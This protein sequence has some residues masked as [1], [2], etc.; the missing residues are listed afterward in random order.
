MEFRNNE[1]Y[2]DCLKLEYD[3]I[4]TNRYIDSINVLNYIVDNEDKLSQKMYFNFID[5]YTDTINDKIITNIMNNM[6]SNDK[7]L[8][9]VAKNIEKNFSNVLFEN[10]IIYFRNISEFIAITE[11]LFL[12]EEYIEKLYPHS[13]LVL[14][15]RTDLSVMGYQYVS[16][17]TFIKKLY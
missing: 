7:N 6:K 2:L 14:V 16:N 1:A 4:Y 13:Y 10:Q 11:N 15:S 17:N 12:L 8:F 5:K 3:S 9:K